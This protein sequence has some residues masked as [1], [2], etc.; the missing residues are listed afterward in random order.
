[1]NKKKILKN[2]GLIKEILAAATALV[3]VI[4]GVMSISDGYITWGLLSY[5]NAILLLI[6]LK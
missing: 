6:Y 1:M 5:I 2:L 4:T 3:F